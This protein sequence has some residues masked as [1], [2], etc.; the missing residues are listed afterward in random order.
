MCLLLMLASHLLVS[1]HLFTHVVSVCMLQLLLFHYRRRPNCC[2]VV[3]AK[4]ISWRTT[5]G[6]GGLQQK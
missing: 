4:L 5:T 6:L 1:R 3:A 2:K